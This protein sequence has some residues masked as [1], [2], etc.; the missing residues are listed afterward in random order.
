MTTEKY[1]ARLDKI[2]RP[3]LV[4]NNLFLH[5]DHI[6]IDSIPPT[7]PETT[8]NIICKHYPS[9]EG[10]EGWILMVRDHNDG[11]GKIW[12]ALETFQKGWSTGA[13]NADDIRTGFISE[14]Y[15]SSY[16]V[17]V[18]DGN[19]Q[20]IPPLS[21]PGWDFNYDTGVLIFDEGRPE[22]GDTPQDTIKIKAY[23]YTGKYLSQVIKHL[24][25]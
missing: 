22:T 8:T 15:D 3:L 24:V 6:R 1:Q 13:G 17:G 10:G 4:K 2:E 23:R 14:D 9:E 18:F 12:V 7:A 11:E 5:A 25:G 16:L 20:W 19:D 21:Q